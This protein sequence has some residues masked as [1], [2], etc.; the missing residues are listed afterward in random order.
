MKRTEDGGVASFP[1]APK[2]ARIEPTPGFGPKPRKALRGKVPRLT[3]ARRAVRDRVEA[4]SGGACEI[5][6]EGV[7]TERAVHFHHRLMRSQGG[8]D[9]V[10]NFLHVCAACHTY[11][12][13]HREEAD[14]LGWILPAASPCRGDE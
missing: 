4:R 14:A 10:D 5:G 11:A 9:L 13:L 6:K 2:R 7:C 8:R 12:H 1:K 3:V